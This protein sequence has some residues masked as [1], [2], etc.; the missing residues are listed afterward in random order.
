MDIEPIL[1]DSFAYAQEALVGKWTRW[2]IFI[3]LALPFSLIRFVFDPQKI[4]DG[5]KMN[6]AAIPWGQI[7]GLVILGILLSF[8]ISG[9]MV[10]IYRGIKP[11]PDFTGWTELFVDGVKLA[12]VWFLWVLPMFI[13]LAAGVAILFTTFLSNQ[14]ISISPNWIRLVSFVVLF[15]LVEC[16]LFIIVI[17]FGILGAVRFA[18]TGSIRE[19]I[20]ASA[21]LTTIRSMG[22]V[23]YIVSLVV[24]AVIAIVYG[25]ITMFLSLIPYIGWVLVLIIAPFFSIFFARY[26]TLVYNH[27]EPQSLPTAVPPEVPPV[28]PFEGQLGSVV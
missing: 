5:M 24:F 27:G 25:I 28:V 10:R 21:I 22:W 3:L 15:L 7:A 23:S 26:F 13:V 2:A 20:R 1:S 11:A 18:R 9:Y 14:A 17:L 4:S 8:F 12:I 6:W 19:G 16:I